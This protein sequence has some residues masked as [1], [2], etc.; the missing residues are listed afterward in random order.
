MGGF[1]ALTS[2]VSG[3][4]F[5]LVLTAEEQPLVAVPLG[6]I[7]RHHDIPRGQRGKCHF[8]PYCFERNGGARRAKRNERNGY[9]YGYGLVFGLGWGK[10]LV[11]GRVLP[12]GLFAFDGTTARFSV[13]FL[14]LS[15]LFTLFGNTVFTV[16]IHGHHDIFRTWGGYWCW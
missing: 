13:F 4:R 14:S 16:I 5:W 7:S 15:F 1:P 10:G 3:Q 9:G 12:R 8:T 11:L 6:R 2:G